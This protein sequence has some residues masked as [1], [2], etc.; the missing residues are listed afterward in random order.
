M[1]HWLNGDEMAEAASSSSSEG[2]EEMEGYQDQ[3]G[4]KK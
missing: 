1:I 2:K 4:W 3:N